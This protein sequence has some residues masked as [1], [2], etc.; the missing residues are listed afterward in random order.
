MMRW[1]VTAPRHARSVVLLLLAIAAAGVAAWAARAHI[2]GTVA[3]IEAQNRR[4]WVA[5]IVADQDLM[6]GLRLDAS[7]LALRDFP[8]D[9]VPA[10][11]LPAQALGA[12]EGRTLAHGVPGGD[13]VLWAHLADE[14][15][16]A[17]SAMLAPGRRA[18]TLTR[19]DLRLPGG[20]LAPGDALDIY[21]AFDHDD[22]RVTMPLL[23]AARVLA[24]GDWLLSDMPGPGSE[25]G[26]L[27]LDLSPDD[28]VRVL[29]AR[30]EGELTALL[31][32]ARDAA[33][34]AAGARG[35]LAR[36]L[37]MPRPPAPPPVPVV[38]YG[39]AMG[40]LDAALPLADWPGEMPSSGTGRP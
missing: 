31:R 32:H 12:L 29:A 34:A 13:A 33:P 35:G 28:A 25:S 27:T 30:Q 37:G 1:P 3:R 17:L 16:N 26:T 14:T 11:A 6:P 9:A 18:L 36:V 23:Q 8:A 38:I 21:V 39:D 4:E 5:R 10:A 22:R 15:P 7:H 24:V 2:Q 20:L 19:D 40:A